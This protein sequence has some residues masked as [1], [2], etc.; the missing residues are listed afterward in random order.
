MNFLKITSLLVVC[1]IALGS[2]VPAYSNFLNFH[3]KSNSDNTPKLLEKTTKQIALNQRIWSFDGSKLSS[4]SIQE[5]NKK[6]LYHFKYEKIDEH[7]LVSQLGASSITIQNQK[8]SLTTPDQVNFSKDGNYIQF[9][10]GKGKK[11]TKI[12]LQ[13]RA[14]D[15]SGSPI[16]KFLPLKN[17]NFPQL[18]T[19]QKFP[20]GSIV[21]VPTI[22]FFDNQLVLPV[23][24]SFTN[25][26]NSNEL[27]EN[28]S[29]VPFCFSFEN[30]AEAQAFGI[31]FTRNK[32]SKQ[33]GTFKIIPVRKDTLFCRP[34]NNQV[35]TKGNWNFIKTPQHSAVVLNIPDNID[36]RD[37]GIKL[38]EKNK[39][40]FAFIAPTKGDRVFRPGKFIKKGTQIETERYMFNET[41]ARFIAKVTL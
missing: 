36:P 13:L 30:R 12:N 39:A 4:W 28:F 41:V 25:A 34:L 32:N 27:I 15:V 24:E 16:F 22:K 7:P 2:S 35:I 38:Y 29:K 21:Y 26:R 19:H 37:Y 17:N 1:S 23:K 33:S 18:D 3:S 8:R 20:E 9:Q 5:Q 31:L 14:Y 6:P 40:Q 10:Y 11:T